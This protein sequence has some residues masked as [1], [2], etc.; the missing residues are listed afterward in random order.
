MECYVLT[1]S[2]DASPRLVVTRDI[3]SYDS[4][5][6]DLG[7]FGDITSLHKNE[8]AANAVD[9]TMLI[10]QQQCKWSSNNKVAIHSTTEVAG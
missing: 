9:N 8:D 1:L 10:I 4:E 3:A 7:Y 6:N 2:A 5:S